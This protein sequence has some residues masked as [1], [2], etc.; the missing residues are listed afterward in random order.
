MPSLTNSDNEEDAALALGLSRLSPDEQLAQFRPEG[1]MPGSY[2]YTP[3]N[4]EKDGL[5]L[6]L[7]LSQLPRWLG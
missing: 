5:A 4:D 6:A 1:S 7:R 3:T 2:P